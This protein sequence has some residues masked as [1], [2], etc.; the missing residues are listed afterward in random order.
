M[1]FF[2]AQGGEDLCY[3]S[4]LRMN[5]TFPGVL[6]NVSLP[7]N[8]AMEVIDAGLF[9]NYG[10]TN[11]VQFLY[12]FSDWIAANTAGVVLITIRNP[13]QEA[14]IMQCATESLLQQL[15]KPID[16]VYSAWGNIQDIRND[17]LLALANARLKAQT[18]E[19]E[20]QYAH[21]ADG[22]HAGTDD[23]SLSW[24]LTAE[25]KQGVLEAINAPS[26]QRSLRRLRS[27]LQ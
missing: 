1:R 23:A 16:G 13:R 21:P 19:V 3:M 24:H 25:E 26:N 10:I 20:F 17:R 11:A 15:T 7:S 14:E 8:P 12:V 22:R 18:V 2:A 5:A 9:D 27:L 4:A 6:P